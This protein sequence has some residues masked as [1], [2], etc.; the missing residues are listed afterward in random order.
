MVAVV[1]IRCGEERGGEGGAGG[2]D[3]GLFS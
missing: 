1:Q 3:G 2:A